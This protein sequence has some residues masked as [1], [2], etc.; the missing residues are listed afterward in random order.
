VLVGGLPGTGK[1]AV[2]D[3]LAARLPLTVLRTDEVRA[4]ER[5][6]EPAAFGEGRYRADA[7]AATYEQLLGRAGTLLE[8][9]E[10]VVLDASWSSALLRSQARDL[11]R[12]TTSD[13]VELR[14]DAAATVATARINARRDRGVDASE[15]TPAIA[16]E[17]AARFAAW[18]EA[19]TI[20]TSAAL[21]DCADRAIGLVRG[22]PAG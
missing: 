10:S 1:S 20:D 18:P 9:G 8:R 13:L 6:A 15:A 21:D 19:A 14:C 3:A 22:A 5:S 7:I 17:M 12:A 11:A 16:E 2:S 4:G